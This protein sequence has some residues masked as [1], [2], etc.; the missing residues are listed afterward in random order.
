MS[1]YDFKFNVESGTVTFNLCEMIRALSPEQQE[2]LM[3]ITAIDES[4]EDMVMQACID[5]LSGKTHDELSM[6]SSTDDQA[7]LD[8]LAA[9]GARI[10]DPYLSY[11]LYDSLMQLLKNM[12]LHQHIY[13][14]MYHEPDR[15]L[16]VVFTNW[17]RLHNIE[18]NFTHK[19]ANKDEIIAWL[20]DC[21]D[22]IV[23]RDQS[24][25]TTPPW[26]PK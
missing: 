19:L 4:F 14:A 18:S 9:V 1:E 23:K 3:R 11:T 24:E 10:A 22:R 7:R 5:R 25:L 6:W 20:R 26:E 17:L 13:W 16:Q 2:E 15:E 8:L 21:F 12:D